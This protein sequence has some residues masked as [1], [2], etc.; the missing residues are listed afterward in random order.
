M[1]RSIKRD[2]GTQPC[3]S[4]HFS[5][6]VCRLKPVLLYYAYTGAACADLPT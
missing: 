4:L 6:Y 1:V 5:T 2:A 3:N